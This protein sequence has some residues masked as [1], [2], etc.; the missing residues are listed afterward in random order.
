M[1]FENPYAHV[2][3]YQKWR[4]A[5][6]LCE[7]ARIDP[8]V[9]P[10]F[11]IANDMKVATA[12]SCFAQHIA[13][14]ISE[15]GFNYFCPEG[16]EGLSEE[17]RKRDQYGVFSARYG[18]LYT[19]HQLRQ[20]FREAVHGDAKAH[21]VL[22][23]S[24]GMFVDAFRPNVSPEGFETAEQV[25]AAREKHLAQVHRVFSEAD[26]FVFTLGLTEAWR[27]VKSGHVL[28]LAPGV[29][30]SPVD[31]TSYEFYNFDVDEIRSELERF[32][33]EFFE[34][35]PEAK[36]LLTVSPV[37]LIAT[38]EDRHVI[39]STTYSKSVLRVA[40]EGVASRHANVDYFPSYEIITSSATS[41]RYYEDDRREVSKLGVAHAMRCFVDAY[42]SGRMTSA[43]PNG[44]MEGGQS[45]YESMASV[46]CD[47]EEIDQ[48]RP[49]PNRVRLENDLIGD[50]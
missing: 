17:E 35:N 8:I 6:S 36:I 45:Q 2:S 15:L 14:Q 28:P 7:S 19:V 23:R 9:A 27:E 50:T 11:A 40:V 39:V 30:G 42:T 26:V 49:A 41:D 21:I 24:D 1:A 32:V 43:H 18:N 5:V 20:L 37:P 48:P 44:L 22:E 38:Y 47:E 16:G 13:R 12:G 33:V 3:D 10:K 31:D 34:L 29:V 46:I 25:H 4:R